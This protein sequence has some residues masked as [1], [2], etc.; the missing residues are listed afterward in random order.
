[1]SLNNR[2]L[3]VLKRLQ[4][5][6]RCGTLHVTCRVRTMQPDFECVFEQLYRLQHKE[7]FHQQKELFRQLLF[8]VD[9][10]CRSSIRVRNS[11]RRPQW[12]S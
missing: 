12:W 10:E 3:H 11:K 8:H 4:D 2:R 7:Y 6:S 9:S 1:M 5:H